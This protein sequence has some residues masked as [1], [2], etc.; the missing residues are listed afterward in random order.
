MKILWTG[1]MEWKYKSFICRTQSNNGR[2]W[3]GGGYEEMN[4]LAG[5]SNIINLVGNT[6]KRKIMFDR[7]IWNNNHTPANVHHVPK[8]LRANRRFSPNVITLSLL[9]TDPHT[10]YYFL[11]IIPSHIATM[12]ESWVGLPYET[13]GDVCCQL[14]RFWS[15]LGC[16]GKTPIFLT[17]KVSFNLGLH[18]MNSIFLKFGTISFMGQKKLEPCQTALL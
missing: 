6:G 10:R 18:K 13:D 14:S 2:E 1:R 3:V 7:Q 9:I 15:H 11:S 4:G 17:V 12:T 16:P 5:N 8:L